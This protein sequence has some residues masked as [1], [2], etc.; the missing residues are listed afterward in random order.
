[1]LRPILAI[2]IALLTEGA[3]MEWPKLETSMNRGVNEN[4]V[5]EPDTIPADNHNPLNADNHIISPMR[6]TIIPPMRL[7]TVSLRAPN[8]FSGTKKCRGRK[9]QAAT[10][11]ISRRRALSKTFF[12]RVVLA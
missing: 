6:I 4:A 11:S 9:Q 3:G 12:S 5:L 7:S 10:R 1:M 2:N 8:R